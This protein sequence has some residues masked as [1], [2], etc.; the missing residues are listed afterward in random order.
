MPLFTQVRGRRILRSPDAPSCI[1][2]VLSVLCWTERRGTDRFDQACSIAINTPASCRKI[3][4]AEAQSSAL[5]QKQQTTDQIL[6]RPPYFFDHTRLALLLP[7]DR[8]WVDASASSAAD[9]TRVQ[10]ATSAS[11]A[12]MT[13]K[14]RARPS[15]HEGNKPTKHSVKYKSVQERHP[16]HKDIPPSSDQAVPVE[17]GQ[18]CSAS[19]LPVRGEMKVVNRSFPGVAFTSC[20]PD[21]SR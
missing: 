19:P 18:S 10:K 7:A 3:G 13:G 16:S 15:R 11:A 1:T 6:S 2:P 4:S 21:A 5:T 9:N 17:S 12:R 14:V 8:W 20:T